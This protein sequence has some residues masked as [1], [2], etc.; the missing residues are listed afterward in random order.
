MSKPLLSPTDEL[1][2]RLT[3]RLG[4]IPVAASSIRGALAAG[5]VVVFAVWAFAG[6]ELIRSLGDVERRVAG[7]HAAF[8]HAADTLSIIRRNVLEA[9]IDVRDALIDASHGARDVYRDDL[10]VQR[11]EIAVQMAAYERQIELAAERDEWTKLES[12]I[13]EYWASIEFVFADDLPTNTTR[14]ATLLRRDVL[15]IRKDVLALLDN[16]R[17]L[18][19]TSQRQHDAEVARLYVDARIRFVWIVAGALVLGI[20]AA[21][22]AWWHVAGL[23]REIHRQRMGEVQNRRDLER[24]SA[25]LVDAQEDERRSLAR[26]LHDEVGQALTAIKMGVGVALRSGELSA[27]PHAA[28]EEA[29]GIAETTLQGVRDLSQLLHPSMLDDFGLPE[30][31]AA[32]VRS[33]S[34][35]TGIRASFQH[36]GLTARCPAEVEVCVYRIV[37]EALTNVARHSGAVSCSVS[38]RR[39]LNHVHVVIDDSGR[40]IS[41]GGADARRGLGLM[42]MRERAQALEGRF[43]IANRPEGGTRVE[44][45]LPAPDRSPAQRRAS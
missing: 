38:V 34:T 7:E 45:V 20:A 36:E 5:F 33:F 24:L 40:G 19:R 15:P 3:I 4:R 35:R 21:W 42:G 27:R 29:R 17:T 25:R 44:V 10:R 30:T 13:G 6:Y 32:Y 14:A 39:V 22:F 16:L 31:L 37:Q 18:Q 26:E 2:R 43:A 9:S 23:E 28:L 12:A 1:V 8:A 11:D 41:F